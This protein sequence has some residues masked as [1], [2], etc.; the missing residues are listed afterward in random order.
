MAD[1]SKRKSEIAAEIA[2]LAKNQD[3]FEY[4]AT[5]HQLGGVMSHLSIVVFNAGVCVVSMRCATL[6]YRRLLG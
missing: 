4:G 2:Q 3:A 5:E 1:D 6:E